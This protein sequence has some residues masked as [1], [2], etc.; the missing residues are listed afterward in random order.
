MV[1]QGNGGMEHLAPISAS[2]KHIEYPSSMKP[3]LHSCCRRAWLLTKSSYGRFS[4]RSLATNNINMVEASDGPTALRFSLSCMD[5]PPT[6]KAVPS[7]DTLENVVPHAS[8][9]L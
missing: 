8:M 4:L 2:E 1:K 5:A 6:N 9:L 7:T 3:T